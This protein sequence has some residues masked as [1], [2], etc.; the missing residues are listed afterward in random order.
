MLLPLFK[1]RRKSFS[2]FFHTFVFIAH[3][4]LWNLRGLKDGDQK[5]NV[6]GQ[7]GMWHN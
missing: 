3:I 1:E 7:L 5:K 4:L 2:S 6:R